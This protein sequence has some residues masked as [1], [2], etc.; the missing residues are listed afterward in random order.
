MY[1][2][3]LICS[4]E[5][6]HTTNKDL[7][8]VLYPQSI[9]K[10]RGA[11]HCQMAHHG[12]VDSQSSHTILDHTSANLAQKETNNCLTKIPQTMPTTRQET[13]PMKVTHK[14]PTLRPRG[15]LHCWPLS[16]QGSTGV[17]VPL[18]CICHM[19]HYIQVQ[20]LFR[21]VL[22]YLKMVSGR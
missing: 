21:E 17:T 3:C 16:V 4:A 11:Q 19:W 14:A 15:A 10:Q 20:E 9:I 6:I 12:D 7:L 1:H 2:C 5:C 18:E 13:I 22:H 8:L